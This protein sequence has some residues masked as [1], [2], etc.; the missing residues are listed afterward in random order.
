MVRKTSV[1]LFILSFFACL[2]LAPFEMGFAR[3]GSKDA[4]SPERGITGD[5]KVQQGKKS[6]RYSLEQLQKGLSRQMLIDDA[7]AVPSAPTRTGP[8]NLESATITWFPVDSMH[9]A[10]GP[11]SR[12]VKP[13]AYDQTTNGLVI[14]HRGDASSYAQ[15]SGEL[16]F[17]VSTD[18][19][20]TW[21]R[22]ASL[23]ASTGDLLAR[24]PGCA[25]WNPHNKSNPSS[26]SVFFVFAAPQL[27]P[28]GAS[29]GRLVYGANSSLTQ[30]NSFAA[31]EG[32]QQYWSN[33]PIWAGG[34]SVNSPSDFG[35]YW[36]S[37]TDSDPGPLQWE[38]WRTADY[39][40][41]PHTIPWPGTSFQVMGLDIAGFYRNNKSYFSVF[42]SFIGDLGEVWNVGYVV[43]T[44]Q[45]ATWSGWN[46]PG[47]P[48][49]GKD[50]RAVPGIR[51]NI[52]DNWFD[53][54]GPGIH[55]FDMVV[56]ANGRV[57]FFGVVHDFETDQRAVVEVYESASGWASK[58][59]QNDIKESTDLT[60]PGSPTLNQMGHHLNAAISADGT[61]M[62]LVWLDA[63]VEGNNLPEI[64]MSYRHISGG[65][66]TPQNLTLTP[67]FAELLL[68]CA[69]TLKSNGGGSY[70]IFL[71]RSYE[72]GVTTYPPNNI[73]RT[74][75]YAG[76]T[77]F[78][79]AV[80]LTK[81]IQVHSV[82]VTPETTTIGTAVTVS[83][84]IENYGSESNP[85][86]V[87]LTYKDGS[88]P[89]NSGDG[90]SQTFTPSWVGTSATVTFSAAHATAISGMVNMFVRAFYAG[91]QD[92]SND[93]QFTPHLVIAQNDIAAISFDDPANTAGK[94]EN[95]PFSPKATFRNAGVLDQTSPFNVK[96]QIFNSVP[97]LVYEN[98]QSIASLVSGANIQVTFG[99]TPGFSVGVYTIRAI[100]LLS[101]DQLRSNDTISGTINVLPV[102]STFPYTEDFEGSGAPE[103]PMTGGYGWHT[104]YVERVPQLPSGTIPP[105]RTNIIDWVRGTPAKTW[106]SGAHGGDKCYVTKLTG[107]Y[108][109]Q[110]ETFLGSPIFNF[111][112]MSGSIAIE[113][114]Q[115]MKLEPAWDAGV[116]EYSTNGGLTWARLDSVLGWPPPD[117]N[118]AKSSGWYNW[119][120]RASDSLGYLDGIKFSHNIDSVA[121]LD[122]IYTDLGYP[123]HT[124]GWYRSRSVLNNVA[125]L[126]DV[127]FRFHFSSDDAVNN[128]GWAIDDFSVSSTAVTVG[129]PVAQNWNIVSLPVS[130]PV[131]GDSV[132]QVFVNSVNP[133]AFRFQNG[134]VQS[135]ILANGPGYWI[136]S[137]A[138]Y[139]QNIT[140]QPRDTLTV[141]VSSGWN[142]IGSIT[143][144]ID[145]SVA[146]VTPSVAGLRTSAF[147]K[148]SNGYVISATIDPGFGY[149]VKASQNGSFFMHSAA[150]AGKPQ[151]AP[152]GRSI[153]ELNTV[154]ITDANGGSQTLYF[155]AD[156][157]SE[158]PVSMYA[159]PP[160]PPQ[161][162]FDARFASDDG[163]LMV[164]THAPTITDA[165]SFPITVQSVAYPLTVTWKVT[166]T[167]MAYELRAG[168][169]V[170]Q[171]LR[172]EGTL[173]INGEVNHLT[174]S[175][176]GSGSEVP[177]EFA[178]YQNYPNPFNPTTTIKFA[179]PVDSK[180]AV[181]VYNLLGQRVRTLMNE[182]Q[183][184]GYH[185]IEWDGKDDHARSLSSGVYFVKMSAD[186]NGKKFTE[187]KKLMMLK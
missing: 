99:A 35:I 178:L 165:V 168:E 47:P 89:A 153:E 55:S 172:G 6:V 106:I 5:Q 80:Q 154:T 173:R 7:H 13:M 137:S 52:Y 127:R 158:I 10:F 129:V 155:G 30:D 48:S 2:V 185:V 32:A 164:Q 136:K 113:F 3:S 149:W 93:A 67:G 180:V 152:G 26:D 29:F 182:T 184:A 187:V 41:I 110:T 40:N 156:A 49:A 131:P 74:I 87:T 8:T 73:N 12:S 125:G 81:N 58:I 112:S 84:V 86:S 116:V 150:P 148:Y 71:G 51:G 43:S 108:S 130:S 170:V 76:S 61:V 64:W 96:Y 77:T 95:T 94:P 143:T 72:A 157:N 109:D 183:A 139:T 107:N 85:T 119:G 114:W 82:T 122:T 62:S 133:Y 132:L 63:D 159:M 91:D 46:A 121:A 141:P 167:D 57:H 169:G 39:V 37:R 128:E 17:N 22:V 146:H 69:P 179:L 145:T 44:N 160:A 90:T 177:T 54:G 103:S 83:A 4:K 105:A 31:I 88:V 25:I 27:Q 18:G 118:T 111:S 24:Y 162:S 70:T 176:T 78:T 20:S 124:N 59:I 36:A 161:G 100:A 56:D 34:G 147:F 42:S 65:W 21:T 97:S 9:N 151:A 23:N 163:G 33:Q 16:W 117:Y 115:N 92:P 144:Q 79:G 140:G 98:V 120:L 14:L 50:F 135:F 101:T 28:G 53:F 126:S 142:M 45:G 134:Y 1:A 19:G 181:E 11:A 38:L 60:Y 123:P 166:G 66:S 15:T 175:V 171:T 174:L 186:G 102:I 138:T 104:G 75:F 68:H